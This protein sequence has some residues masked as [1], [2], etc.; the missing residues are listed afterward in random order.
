MGCGA[1]YSCP[2]CGL[3]VRIPEVGRK[4]HE[5]SLE[6]YDDHFRFGRSKDIILMFL[7]RYANNGYN[8]WI[9]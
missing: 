8:I 5:V 6:W 4:C 3:Q 7:S 9:S 1:E 2:G